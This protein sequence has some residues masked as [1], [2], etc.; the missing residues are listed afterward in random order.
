MDEEKK[1][2]AM[3]GHDSSFDSEELDQEL[4]DKV[5]SNYDSDGSNNSSDGAMIH[6]TDLTYYDV[7]NPD[8]KILTLNNRM[9]KLKEK[10]QLMMEDIKENEVLYPNAGVFQDKIVKKVKEMYPS[11]DNMSNLS[12]YSSSASGADM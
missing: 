11:D 2:N 1:A 12:G 5:D 8:E 7:M 9:I 3:G 10:Q 4:R 6:N